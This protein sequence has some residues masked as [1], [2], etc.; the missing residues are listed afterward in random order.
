MNSKETM[1]TNTSKAEF[2]Q[3][4]IENERN[5]PPSMKDYNNWVIWKVE[6]DEKGRAT[7]VPYQSK[8]PGKKAKSTDQTTWSS[9]GECIAAYKACENGSIDGIGFVV[10]GT[11]FTGVD[12]D[13]CRDRETGEIEPWAKQI[14]D[15][16]QSYWEI[17]PSGTGIR[18]YVEGKIPGKQG[19]RKGNIEIYGTDRFFTVSGN[20]PPGFKDTM[21]RE[22]ELNEVYLKYIKK[23]KLE[24]D[25]ISDEDFK[26]LCGKSRLSDTEVFDHAIKANDKEKFLRLWKNETGLYPSKKYR[27][28]SEADLALCSIL[29]FWT[30]RDPVV[31]DRLYRQS[32][33]FTAKWDELRGL[34]TY[35]AMTI[36]KAVKGTENIYTPDERARTLDLHFPRSAIRGVAKDFAD[37]YSSALESPWVFLAFAFL[38]FLGC[39]VA[40]QINLKSAIN[41]QPRFYTALVGE[42]A[43][44]R[45]TTAIKMAKDFFKDNVLPEL[46]ISSLGIGISDGV[47]S[48][49]GLMNFLEA[50]P[51]TI[52][53]YD[54]L[55]SFVSKSGI[56]TSVLLQAVNSLFELN[57]YGT[58]TAHHKINIQNAYLSLIG[59]S[60]TETFERM[61]TPAFLDIGFMNRLFLVTG[62]I[63]KLHPIPGEISILSQQSI[64]KQL[65]KN[66]KTVT[67]HGTIDIEQDARARFNEWYNKIDRTDLYSKRL[68]TYGLRLFELFAVS[69]GATSLSEDLVQRVITV[70][71]WQRNVREVHYPIDAVGPVA[72]MEGSI[73]RLL[74][75][76]PLAKRELQKRSHSERHGL[77]TFKLAFENLKEAGLVKY[78]NKTGLYYLPKE[79]AEEPSH[80]LG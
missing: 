26:K 45:K 75:R 69:E 52:L 57:T 42:S 37:L 58:Q 14:I 33:L 27:S 25:Y 74:A 76:G 40:D 19:C 11:P 68:D 59:A 61:F 41:P 79:L 16:L 17:T 12:L 20:S 39:F 34:Q 66:I 48:A 3:F 50:T 77:Y 71:D 64:V 15:A 9:Y 62:V 51:K 78:N 29:A 67:I 70:L 21:P 47:G 8:Y 1:N 56:E 23:G 55:K 10:K 65:I 6:T 60:T 36:K 22:K 73:R 18:V 38:T 32:K 13:H 49:E 72:N 31:I 7:K 43:F 46:N 28:K 53:V 5:I 80:G 54:E 30:N 63:E 4:N 24:D 35:G 2:E 44:D